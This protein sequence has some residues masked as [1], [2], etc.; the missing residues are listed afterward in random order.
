MSVMQR[1]PPRYFAMAGASIVFV[2]AGVA[3]VLH[4]RWP[5]LVLVIV[6][7]ALCAVGIYDLVQTRHAI[8]RNYPI[9]AHFRF[10]F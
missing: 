8:L 9:L 5:W 2:L 10:F 6:A 1:L 3:S 7:G 4:P